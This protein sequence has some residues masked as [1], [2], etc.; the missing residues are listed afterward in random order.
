MEAAEAAGFKRGDYN[1]RDRG[2]VAVASLFQ[3]T[4]KEGKR[5]ST[6]QAF[7]EANPSNGL[8]H[9]HNP[10]RGDTSD[11]EGLEAKG[12][13]YRTSAGEIGE[14]RADK[15]SHPLRVLLALRTC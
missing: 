14:V 13:V 2:G 5:S 11:P 12:V 7:L 15:G 8:I 10:R 4:T 9:D 6:Y 1:G 3:T